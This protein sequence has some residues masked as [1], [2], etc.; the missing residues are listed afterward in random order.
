MCSLFKLC[1]RLPQPLYLCGLL[2]FLPPEVTFIASTFSE[3]RVWHSQT[4]KSIN[5]DYWGKHCLQI[6]I[7]NIYL[8]RGGWLNN[9]IPR[10]LCNETPLLL[11]P[12]ALG[13]NQFTHSTSGV[14][15]GKLLS[16]LHLGT[17]ISH[18]R[19]TI[20][21]SE[22]L[23]YH[24]SKQQFVWDTCWTFTAGPSRRPLTGGSNVN[25]MIRRC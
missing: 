25:W 6:I 19:V 8:C 22:P 2:L 9:M 3:T 12:E 21:P 11:L 5:R 14:L 17:L 24:R 16:I 4:P 18:L 23:G 15:S 13:V 10:K 7:F 1:I 20:S